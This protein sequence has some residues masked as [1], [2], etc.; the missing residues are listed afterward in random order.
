MPDLEKFASKHTLRIVTIADLIQYRFLTE[1]LVKRVSERTLTFDQTASE[2]RAIVYETTVEGREFLALVKGDVT[3]GPP[4]LCRVHSG[5]VIADVFASTARDGGRRLR[6][7]IDRMEKEGRGVIVYVTPRGCARAELDA[8]IALRE[9]PPE[10]SEP[11]LREF[12]LG[13]QVLVD[14]GVHQI[15]LLT[16]NPR[17]IAGIHGFGLDVLERIPLEGAKPGE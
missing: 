3:S 7:C 17:K 8:F 9:K 1:S 4:P 14:L 12:G 6:D 11:P 5:S 10:K 15:R 13:A 16:D 2:W